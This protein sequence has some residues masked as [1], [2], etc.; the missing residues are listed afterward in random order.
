M[1]FFVNAHVFTESYPYFLGIYNINCYIFNAI[2]NFL[3]ITYNKNFLFFYSDLFFILER[4]MTLTELRYVVAIA[5]YLHFGKAAAASH[6][7]QPSLSM[8]IKKLE[9]ELGVTIFERRNYDV[10]ITPIGEQLIKQAE[11][12]LSEIQQFKE[13]ALQGKDPFAGLLKIGVIYTIAPYLL[14]SFIPKLQ[15]N[16][17]TLQLSIQENYTSVLL[18]LLKNGELDLLILSEPIQ[19]SGITMQALYDE[20][21]YVVMPKNHPWTQYH[22]IPAKMLTQENLLLLSAGNCFRDQVLKVYPDLAYEQNVLQKT[23]EGS[24]LQTIYHMVACRMGVT[25]LPSTTIRHGTIDH[26]L[27]TIRPFVEPIPK[28]RIVLAWRNHFSRTEI[29]QHVRQTILSLPLEDIHF[30]PKA[31]KEILN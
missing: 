17:S 2:I 11:R 24:S 23:L 1:L 21:F 16:A 9:E 22:A 7:S 6:V 8:G 10:K 26:D 5:K 30:L 28:R 20:P 18:N 12:I 27:V 19:A 4:L 15:E 25:V 14:P 3:F 29:V 13:I 31:K